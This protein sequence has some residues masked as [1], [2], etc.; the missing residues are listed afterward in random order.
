MVTPEAPMPQ[1]IQERFE[2]HALATPHATAL[3]HG[4]Q[5]TTYGELNRRANQVAHY[6]MHRGIASGSLVAVRLPRG[7]S[8]I[9]VLLGILKAGCGYAP[10][11]EDCPAQRRDF[12]LRDTAA[13]ALIVADGNSVC[14]SD[15]PD[16]IRLD[17][18]AA[19]LASQSGDCPPNVS[20]SLDVAYCMYSSGS[21][22]VPKGILTPHAGVLRLVCEPDYVQLD[23]RQVVLHA[24]PL[25]FDASTF[26][27]W[28]ALL[29]G[30][31]LA[32]L[33]SGPVTPETV[34]AAVERHG[35]TTAWLTA[36]L[37]H[38]SGQTSF[39]GLGSLRQLL[40][41][42]DVLRPDA[43]AHAAHAL[44][45]CM[46]VNGYG[47][48]E[49]TTFAICG[50]ALA[51]EN[52]APVPLGRPINQT[53]VH[54][55]DEKGEPVASGEVG[56][57]CIAG[58][59]LARGYLNRP[60][61]TAERFVPNPFG[62][63][64]SR[65]YKSGDLGR[66]RPDGRIDFIGRIDHQVKVNGYRIELG[67]VEAA[68]A[69]LPEVHEVVVQA[70]EPR[71]GHKR[72][73]CYACAKPGQRLTIEGLRAALAR[74]LPGYMIPSAWI[75]LDAFPQNAS[76]KIE[77]RAL[78]PPASSREFL[79]TAYVPPAS[80]LELEMAALW[81]S[82]L[83]IDLVGRQDTFAAL[84]GSSIQA[85]DISFRVGRTLLE[86]RRAPL[87][88]ANSTLFEYTAACVEA[89]LRT[90]S[91]V[92][93][94]ADEPAYGAQAQQQVW[95][96]EQL[97]E[98]WRAYRFHARFTIEG[99]LNVDALHGALHALVE[100]HEILRT[101]FVPQEGELVRQIEQHLTVPLPLIDL[102]GLPAAER[103]DAIQDCIRA[104]LDHRF[105]IG[106]APLIRW[107]LVRLEE[108]R[109]VLLQSEHHFLH[110]GQSFRILVND[111]AALYNA[112]SVD[113]PAVLPTIEAQYGTYCIDERRWLQT[114]EF[115]EQLS[116]WRETLAPF[117]AGGRLFANRPRALAPRHIGAQARRAI[118][119]ELVKRIDATA[120]GLGISRFTLMLAAFGLLCG[121]HS[122]RQR[123]L[124]GTALA[125]RTAAKHQWTMGM[126]V[127]MLPLPFDCDATLAFDQF[128]HAVSKAVGFTLVNSRVPL[129]QIVKAL[130]LSATL[131]GEAPF[132][133]GFSFHDSLEAR[134]NF[135]GLKVG[136]D[137][138]IA[139]GVAKFDLD[140]VVIAGNEG[141]CP[142][143]ELLFEYNTDCFDADS[144]ERL[145]DHYDVL[146]KEVVGD[147]RSR[148]GDLPL[149]PAGERRLLLKDFV[150]TA[151]D[152]NLDQD[153]PEAFTRQAAAT[154]DA[155]AIVAGS[156][157]MTY[158]ELDRRSNQL[159]H[160]L[161]ACGVG[162]EVF[163]IVAAER[164]VE[165]VLGLLGVLKAGG[166]YVPL[167]P[168]YPEQ[169]RS[170]ILADTNAPVML[171][172]VGAVADDVAKTGTRVICL[173]SQWET[174]AQHSSLPPAR[175]GAVDHLA[176]CIFTSGS[177]GRPKGV[178]VSMRSLMNHAQSHVEACGLAP[179]DR[180]LQICATGFDASLEEI[181][182]TL[183][184]GAALVIAPQAVKVPNAEFLAW[185]ASERLTFLDLPT[186]FWSA[187]VAHSDE[188]QPFP[189]TVRLTMIGGEA[190]QWEHVELAQRRSSHG[191]FELYNSYGP[192]ETTIIATR[193]RVGTSPRPD[194]GAGVPLGR[195]IANVEVYV[196]DHRFAPVPVG[197]TG[198]ICICGVA[199][200]RGYLNRPDL[201]A[202]KFVPNPFG[203]PGSRLYRTGDLGTYLPDGQL[204]FFGRSDQQVKIRG[205]RI[206]LGEVESALLRCS[207]IREVAVMARALVQGE[208][209]HLVG[210]LVPHEGVRPN[211][212]A[213]RSELMQQL[214]EYMVPT[215][216][217]TLDKLPL[218]VNGKLDRTSLPMPVLSLPAVPDD[219]LDDSAPEEL[220]EVLGILRGLLPS[221]A[222]GPNDDLLQKG[223]HSVLLL[224]LLTAIKAKFG[225]VLKVRDVYRLATPAALARQVSAMLDVVS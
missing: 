34:A 165:L 94:E 100:R 42:G 72:L 6:L 7:A 53:Q 184:C 85:I 82:T 58:A 50:V 87:P 202:E 180:V 104:E 28:G 136:V 84:G 54:L 66:I 102:S 130:N 141:K 131:Q 96:L 170:C 151:R 46:V 163:V 158:A 16:V 146:L 182:P 71:P 13:C 140:V 123:F 169:R 25:A 166:V 97:G 150:D 139:T 222:I 185:A 194:N 39:K 174:V 173:D 212:D 207:G 197:V 101:S 211:L 118:S 29:N 88:L 109:H 190:A 77:R 93:L 107:V 201:T 21:T 41:G 219:L 192:T 45:Q 168:G 171:T 44:P 110:D 162:P 199:L 65:L 213:L 74:R 204:A 38:R 208:E 177:T 76:G 225:V 191:A 122:G 105:D 63:P 119:H 32:I 161:R 147:P 159:A 157:S 49:T 114:V 135:S 86:G 1:S 9:T 14:E 62:P 181:V 224:R 59:G 117:V 128:A 205:Y 155:V 154:P 183:I 51:T 35:V 188:S 134:P 144:I 78:P 148:L 83:G 69:K 133:V 15:G 116:A 172:T 203:P 112:A 99:S 98:G 23:A 178:G 22:G 217:C 189:S 27:I 142:G 149:L 209:L 10:I 210:Y 138:A 4:H 2:S 40:A 92:A 221:S 73:V 200:A 195:A 176:Y 26:E 218:N 56:E 175:L 60:D 24:A 214:P 95:F 43:V 80:E 90:E 206:E 186:S 30:A 61:L 167:D 17:E 33:D 5:R 37:F 55:L 127:N 47:P 223:M 48:T 57:I 160:H 193:G 196:V 89:S 164:G 75:F 79:G 220:I 179:S 91:G 18:V 156:R 124:L 70:H 120:A 3:A 143:L 12:I 103:A 121:R 11:D 67:E 20:T 137:E 19:E 106:C 198:E 152:W 52:G 108:H 64:G 36:P 145:L 113:Q 125:N 8:A 153:V 31:T 115:R 129:G 126:F 81:A 68:I 187:L 215:A 216:W 132:N 111:L